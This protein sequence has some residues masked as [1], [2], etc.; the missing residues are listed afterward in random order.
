MDEHS[1]H[2]ASTN[3]LPMTDLPTALEFLHKLDHD[4]LQ[5]LSQLEAAKKLGYASNTSTPFYRRVTASKLFGLLDTNQGMVL[6]RLALDYFKP[7]DEDS[8]HK[9]L[10]SA[11]KNVVGYQKIIE[12]YSGKRAPTPEILANLIERDHHLTR[13]ASIICANVFLQS[14]RTASMLDAYGS[15]VVERQ[16][17]E[18]APTVEK[19]APNPLVD[20]RQ[21]QT[22]QFSPPSFD[23]HLETHFLTLDR[24]TGRRLILQGPPVITENELRRIQGWLAV[25]FEVVS[26]LNPVEENPSPQDGW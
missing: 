8:K 7:M 20:T 15:I 13:D 9:A 1:G 3:V 4:G 23:K 10:C 25:Q 6:T 21:N 18:P 26:E 11:I 2:K 5:T 19:E 14:V 17:A 12:R 16:S 24:K 22:D